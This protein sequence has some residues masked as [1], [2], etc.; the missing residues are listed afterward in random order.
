MLLHELGH[1]I[2]RD[3]S[4]RCVRGDVGRFVESRFCM[5]E[6]VAEARA[7]D[8]ELAALGYRIRLEGVCEECRRQA[9]VLLRTLPAGGRITID[10]HWLE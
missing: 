2:F 9:S 10:T 7:L 6:S 1:A 4:F 8:A 3:G 5:W